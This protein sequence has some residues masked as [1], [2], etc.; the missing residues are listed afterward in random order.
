MA[1]TTTDSV[2]FVP[3]APSEPDTY[4][5]IR[6]DLDSL[7]GDLRN[8]EGGLTCVTLRET[9]TRGE[10][11]EPDFVSALYC[12]R[13]LLATLYE[14]GDQMVSRMMVLERAAE[15]GETARK[16]VRS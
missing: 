7:M 16:G 13:E 10:Y 2:N 6:D 12:L 8:V 3:Q 4:H 15:E 14:R 9:E 1:T 11:L 5:D